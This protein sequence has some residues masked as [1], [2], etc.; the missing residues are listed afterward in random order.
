MISSF[1]TSRRIKEQWYF[2]ILYSFTLIF[3]WLNSHGERI[4]LY[5]NS[6]YLIS[7]SIGL[8]IWLKKDK[9][10]KAIENI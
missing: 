1:L 2:W 6:F 3:I 10:N 8:Y 5:L 4:Y 9:E 7:N